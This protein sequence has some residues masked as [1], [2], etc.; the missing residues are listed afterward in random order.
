MPSRFYDASDRHYLPRCQNGLPKPKIMNKNDL[1]LSAPLDMQ[2]P[3]MELFQQSGGRYVRYCISLTSNLSNQLQPIIKDLAQTIGKVKLPSSHQFKPVHETTD[4]LDIELKNI[5]SA[6]EWCVAARQHELLVSLIDNFIF[7]LWAS[8]HWDE[9][10]FWLSQGLESALLINDVISK[11]SYLEIHGRLL[12]SKGDLQQAK[13]CF[14]E[15][16][17]IYKDQHDLQGETWMHYHLG[18]VYAS[19]G[20]WNKAIEFYKLAQST[21]DE[22]R[23]L[24]GLSNVCVS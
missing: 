15:A 20:L 16:L 22:Q 1:S 23:N 3:A 14:T 21:F 5:I 7:Y 12:E 19:Q 24:D 18:G 17:K 10:E 8:G 9:L 6:M 2:N 11:A 13:N 4:W